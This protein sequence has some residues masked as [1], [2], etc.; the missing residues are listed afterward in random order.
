MTDREEVSGPETR[1]FVAW[2][3]NAPYCREYGCGLLASDPIHVSGVKG[4][5]PA[6]TSEEWRL[7]ERSAF[8]A[9]VEELERALRRWTEEGCRNSSTRSSDWCGS[10]LSNP[11]AW[12]D[13]CRP[14]HSRAAIAEKVQP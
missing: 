4:E 10:L 1:G 3:G 14:C 6:V 5:A 13:M 7:T 9:R 11:P 2:A 12:G 8:S